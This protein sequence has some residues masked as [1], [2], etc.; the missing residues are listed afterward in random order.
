MKLQKRTQLCSAFS[1]PMASHHC[2]GI[3]QLRVIH[4][5]NTAGPNAKLTN[6]LLQTVQEHIWSRPVSA[7]TRYLTE[8]HTQASDHS[9]PNTSIYFH[10][11]TSRSSA[12]R[13]SCAHHPLSPRRTRRADPCGLHCDGTPGDRWEAPCLSA[14]ER[15]SEWMKGWRHKRFHT[16]FTSKEAYVLLNSVF[17]CTNWGS[18]FLE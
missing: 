11:P 10:L 7:A 6:Y 4:R 5:H 8:Y 1:L 12:G 15:A 13:T 14:E 16:D 2:H 9:H 17:F 3:L 18:V